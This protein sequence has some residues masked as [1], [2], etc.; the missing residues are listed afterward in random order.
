MSLPYAE[1]HA[2]SCYSILDGLPSP[3][4]YILR[5]KEL[6]LNAMAITDHG[7]NA[8]HR[9]MYDAGV[10]HGIKVIL[11]QEMYFNPTETGDTLSKARRDEGENAYHHMIVLAKNDNGLR[12]LNA[13][14]AHAWKHD[15]YQ[16]PR[17]AIDVLADYKED[18][19]VTAACVGGVVGRAIMNDDLDAARNWAIQFKEIMGDDFYGE[20]HAE[21]DLIK[22]GY[23][24]TML[25][26]MD[27]LDIKTVITSDCHFAKLDDLWIEESLLILNTNPKKN[28]EV[29]LNKMQKMELLEKFNYL[30]PDRKMTFQEVQVYLST[31]Q[32]KHAKLL[33]LGLDRPDV[34]Y[35]TIEV[36]DKIGN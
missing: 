1:I 27:S 7:S 33:E 8:G 18:L 29:E 21:D 4:E 17:V 36:S 28:P 20:I 2:H 10:K 6:D 31:A 26:I 5:A 15:F 16:K 24:R 14:S 22:P 9:E 32:E 12:N 35:N 13:M 34:F 25:E 23:T 30:Y 19:I 3:E 11:G